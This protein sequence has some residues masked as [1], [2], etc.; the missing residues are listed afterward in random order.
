MK[1]KSVDLSHAMSSTRSHSAVKDQMKLSSKLKPPF[2]SFPPPISGSSFTNTSEMLASTRKRK[3]TLPLPLQN[4]S[5]SFRSAV[6][7]SATRKNNQGSSDLF[8]Q[9]DNIKYLSNESMYV[10]GEGNSQPQKRHR[11]DPLEKQ[12]TKVVKK[13]YSD[14]QSPA[15]QTKIHSPKVVCFQ[16]PYLNESKRLALITHTKCKLHCNSFGIHHSTAL[17]PFSSAIDSIDPRLDMRWYQIPLSSP[18]QHKSGLF[19]KRFQSSLEEYRRQREIKKMKATKICPCVCTSSAWS[20]GRDE[21]NNRIME[22]NGRRK[23]TDDM[24][25]NMFPVSRKEVKSS[26]DVLPRQL[27]ASKHRLTGSAIS[28]SSLKRILICSNVSCGSKAFS[29]VEQ[30][31]T[32]LKRSPEPNSS[33]KTPSKKRKKALLRDTELVTVPKSFQPHCLNQQEDNWPQENSRNIQL[34]MDA[35]NT[36]SYNS[37]NAPQNTSFGG[38]SLSGDA[39]NDTFPLDWS[40]PRIEVLYSKSLLT[41]LVAETDILE[42]EE[43]GNGGSDAILPLPGNLHLSEEVMLLELTLQEDCFET[44][45]LHGQLEIAE[46]SYEVT[47]S[48]S[49]IHREHPEVSNEC[50]QPSLISDTASHNHIAI[51]NDLEYFS[52]PYPPYSD[53]MPNFT[54]SN[55]LAHY[56][57]TLVINSDKEKDDD[58]LPKLKDVLKTMKNSKDVSSPSYD[59]DLSLVLLPSPEFISPITENYVNSLDYLLQEKIQGEQTKEEADLEEKLKESLLLGY[60]MEHASCNNSEEQTALME[61]HRL[62]IQKYSMTSEGIPTVPPGDNIFSLFHQP[63]LRKQS[64]SLVLDATAL[65]ARLPLEQMLFSATF[66]QQISFVRDGFLYFLY[67]CVPCPEPVLQWLFQLMSLA[68]D[69]SMDCFKALWDISLDTLMKH[70]DTEGYLWCPSLQD[71]ITVLEILGAEP[72]IL[73]PKG[74]LP[75]GCASKGRQFLGFKAKADD[76]GNKESSKQEIAYQFVLASNLNNIFKFLTLC[77]VAQPHQYSDCE[78]LILIPMLCQVSLDKNLR[79]VPKKDLQQLLVI[80]LDNIKTWQETLPEL[81]LSLCQLSMHHHNLLS[82]VQLFPDTTTKG[83][84]LRRYL[85]LVIIAKQLERE[86]EIH[87]FK[88]DNQLSSLCRFLICMKPSSL[89]QHL[90]D[91]VKSEEHQSKEQQLEWEAKLDQEICYLC[92]SLLILANVVVGTETISSSMKSDLQQLCVQLDRQITSNI[93]ESPRFMYRSKLKNLATSTYVKWQELLSQCSASQ[94]DY[95]HCWNKM[96]YVCQ[97]E[98]PSE[99]VICDE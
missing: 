28:P 87:L 17:A 64:A 19:S 49:S 40:P 26:S 22:T 69:I 33:V 88:E 86:E 85:S 83:R 66:S 72:S 42:G 6:K 92:H 91:A 13:S 21:E 47:D 14:S 62:F 58:I 80:L 94:E 73:Y 20:A 27:S 81:C 25:S 4:S 90:E 57:D 55:E 3:I 51:D 36:R 97:A 65:Q 9:R 31:A 67:R 24:K 76:A 54:S 75:K 39:S 78:L 93:R 18:R 23:S 35:E 5:P 34:E 8:S 82:I 89:K 61:E 43:D 95:K 38:L 52:V 60:S 63:C 96:S 44:K 79:N 59:T 77:G 68:S 50:R 15:S 98:N 41:P 32:I 74:S 37:I 71:I 1:P 2:I 10:A 84:S 56:R 29:S 12:M 53:Q 7:T 16:A 46:A 70:G 30:T 45:N 11:M 99:I 48:I